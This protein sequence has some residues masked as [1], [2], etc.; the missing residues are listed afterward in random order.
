MHVKK[1]DQNQSPNRN[2]RTVRCTIIPE[3]PSKLAMMYSTNHPA[4]ATSQTS[5]KQIHSKLE[6]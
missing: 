5:K 4:S 2:A 6:M 3:H 1:E